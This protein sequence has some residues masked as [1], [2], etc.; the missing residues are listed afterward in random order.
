MSDGEVFDLPRRPAVRF[1]QLHDNGDAPILEIVASGLKAFDEGFDLLGNLSKIETVV[2]KPLAVVGNL[3]FRGALT[4]GGFH[5]GEFPMILQ[6]GFGF[7][8]QLS[9]GWKVVSLD[10]DDDG[11][12][13]AEENRTDN[14]LGNIRLVAQVTANSFQNPFFGG[15]NRASSSQCLQSRA[16]LRL[17]KYLKPSGVLSFVRPLHIGRVVSKS[18]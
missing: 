2:G 13:K 8:R 11:F 12:V 7:L 18:G 10:F 6:Q 15:G 3:N 14:L 4:E 1:F 17:C 5:V 16:I 9:Q